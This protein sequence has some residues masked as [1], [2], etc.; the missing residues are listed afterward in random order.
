MSDRCMHYYH[1]SIQ[2]Q[3][4]ISILAND[5]LLPYQP[6]YHLSVRRTCLEHKKN[7]LNEILALYNPE[8]PGIK[9]PLG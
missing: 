1:Y 6:R 9:I 2:P 4:T 8:S 3:H 7:P 5:A